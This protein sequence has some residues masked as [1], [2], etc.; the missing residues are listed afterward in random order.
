MQTQPSR[1]KLHKTSTPG[2]VY[3][4]D[5]RDRKYYVVYRCHGVCGTPEHAKKHASGKN[6]QHQERAY[7]DIGS[8]RT[9]LASR[10]RGIEEKRAARQRGEA[11]VA[12]VA[13]K[14]AEVADEYLADRAFHKLAPGTQKKYSEALNRRVLPHFGERPIGEITTDDIAAWLDDL[15]NAPRARKRDGRAHGLSES[16]V[17]GALS[18]LRCVFNF[19]A[20]RSQKYI[21][22]SP[23]AALEDG[24]RPDCQANARPVQVLDPSE[25]A[26][27]LDAVP[28]GFRLMLELKAGTGLR[29]SEL[30]GLV[31]ADIDLDR[32]RIKV[33]RQIDT[34]DKGERVAIKD[35]GMA[36]HRYVPLTDSL[37]EKLRDHKA[38]MAEYTLNEASAFVFGED[39]H[40]SNGRL[41]RAFKVAMRDA[42]I[43]R[44]P[45]KRL[46]LHSLRHGYGSLLLAGGEQL[47][48]VS[49]WLGHRKLSTTER[50]YVHQIESLDDIAAERMRERERLASS[51]ASTA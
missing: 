29:S 26:R 46:S 35:R 9:I 18:P 44:D 45:D 13:R 36:D 51:V 49:R 12:P 3:R 32:Q 27:L 6:P 8:A 22:A 21:E 41:D 40:V 42:Q 4:G 33:S 43:E 31:W 24:E 23:V 15:R 34:D 11:V 28:D 17:N 25:L 30:R 38:R 16:T 1:T 19:A 20:L 47:V 50:V 7:G 5:S 14:F 48:N 10:K 2:V 39:R 37:T